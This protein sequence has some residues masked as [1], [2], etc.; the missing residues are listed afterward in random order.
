MAENLRGKTRKTSVEEKRNQKTQINFGARLGKKKTVDPPG[1]T[2]RCACCG[3][4]YNKQANNFLKSAK[5]DLFA[6]NNNYYPVCRTCLREYFEYLKDYFAGNSVKAIERMCQI[7]DLFYDD[8]I[9][10]AAAAACTGPTN[11]LLGSYISRTQLETFT[12]LGT[13][14]LDTIADRAAVSID[15]LYDLEQA[16]DG[17][18]TLDQ[19]LVK[20]WGFGYEPEEYTMLDDHY[21]LLVTQFSAASPLEDALIRDLCTIKVLQARAMKQGRS[22]DF[23]KFTKLY[24]STLKAG[25]LK[26]RTDADLA[27]DDTVCWGTLV[28]DVE[29][30]TPAE[31]Y[32]DKK[33]FSD[34]DSIQDYF[35]RFI[36]RPFKN[37]FGGGNELDEEFSI[38][39]GDDRD[40]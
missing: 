5:S 36:V 2:Y 6:G 7:M 20:T 16:N 33:L 25:G 13:T 34:W 23:D 14:Y 26:A 27:N 18:N 1:T 17:E 15:S 28:R 10:E 29:Q 32:K 30:Y 19:K 3:K 39:L 11:S 31:V 35:G 38:Q 37:F 12:L 40:V 4:T 21:K 24:H 8:A 22:D 9:Y